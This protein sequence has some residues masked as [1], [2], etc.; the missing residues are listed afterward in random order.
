MTQRFLSRAGSSAKVQHE[1]QLAKSRLQEAENQ[2][3]RLEAEVLSFSS[4]SS[5]PSLSFVP[6]LPLC[7][8]LADSLQVRDLRRMREEKPREDA[9]SLQ[10]RLQQ[11]TSALLEAKDNATKTHQKLDA[12]RE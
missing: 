11:T 5:S 12:L 8:S 3:G 2:I 6:R 1:L 7:F 10:E 9:A 4:T